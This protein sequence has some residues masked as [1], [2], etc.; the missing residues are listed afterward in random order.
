MT[1]GFGSAIGGLIESIVAELEK[2]GALKINPL[3]K[4]K[5][6]PT[7]PEEKRLAEILYDKTQS[8]D[9]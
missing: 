6:P 9:I 1:F 8:S 4:M 2:S 3:K 5:E 7:T